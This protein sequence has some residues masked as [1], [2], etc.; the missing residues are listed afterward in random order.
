MS[1]DAYVGV[2]TETYE[3]VCVKVVD[4]EVFK[5]ADQKLLL[6]NE[7]RCQKACNSPY[8]I[9]LLDVFDTSSFCFI[10]SEF[11]EG[12]DLYRC[13]RASSNGLPESVVQQ[14]G[15]EVALALQKLRD[16]SI[17]HRDIKSENILIQKNECKL[18]DFGF[19][20]EE[21]YLISYS[22]C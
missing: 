10:I 4:R 18:G 21:K 8:T 12:G 19:A 11:C 20:I 3:L 9:K 7:I 5:T 1:G 22:E 2:N 14:F 6:D 15:R 13:L 16:S 17:I